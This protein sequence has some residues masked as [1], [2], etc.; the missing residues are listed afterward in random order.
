MK[1]FT[2]LRPQTSRYLT[3]DNN[4][5]KESK[6]TKKCVIKQNLK[7]EGYKHFITIEKS[8]YLSREDS[9]AKEAD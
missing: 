8:N 7:F 9:L 4:E 6:S 3:D 2:A 1:E 5:N